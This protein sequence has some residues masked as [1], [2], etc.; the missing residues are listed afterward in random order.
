MSVPKWS[1]LGPVL[2]SIFI[3]D[4]DS[5]DKFSLSKFANDTELS[6]AVDTIEGRDTIQRDLDRLEKWDH[7]ILMRI[8]MEKCRVLH[9]GCGN[10]KYMYRL[11]NEFFESSPVEK[12]LGILVDEQL[13]MSQQ[14]AL[15][16]WKANCILGCTKREVASSKKDVFEPLLLCPHEAPSGVLH[17][18]LESPA[19]EICRAIGAGPEERHKDDERA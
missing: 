13:D 14:R 8:N 7:S 11:G 1:V 2:F 16:A 3:N 6:D 9:F 15:A 12:D 17:L 5:E 19:Q 18:I 4:I 10:L